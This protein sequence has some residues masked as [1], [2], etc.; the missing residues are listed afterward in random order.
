MLTHLPKDPVI[1][2]GVVNTNLRDYY[3]SLEEFCFHVNTSA[4]DIKSR[5]KAIDY[6]YDEKRNQFV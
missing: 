3:P 6:E 2:L 1:L 4:D 5:L